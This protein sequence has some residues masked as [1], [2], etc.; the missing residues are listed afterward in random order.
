MN[1]HGGKRDG[2]GRKK[3]ES[4]RR[5]VSS[6]RYTSAELEEVTAAAEGFGLTVANYIRM[7]V[8]NMIGDL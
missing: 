6:Q 8:T 3:L 5:H 1:T 4:P 2:A 7:K